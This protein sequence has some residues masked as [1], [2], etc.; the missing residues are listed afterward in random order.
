MKK[1][2]FLVMLVCVFDSFLVLAA[3]ENNSCEGLRIKVSLDDT[4]CS[5]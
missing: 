5:G 3:D 2:L 1:I 4:A